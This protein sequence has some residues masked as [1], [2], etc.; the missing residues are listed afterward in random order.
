MKRDRRP[1]G[2]DI[3]QSIAKR[4]NVANH[5]LLIG[6]VLTLG[7][8]NQKPIDDRP[9]VLFISIDDLRP[10]LG[11]YDDPI[12]ITPNI[13]HLA[14]E[15]I[16]FRQAFCQAAVSAPSRASLMTGLRPDSTRVWHLGD[17]FRIIHPDAVTMPQYF[18]GSGYY[19]V[20]IGKIFHNYMPDSISWDEPDL[21]PVQYLREEWLKRDGETFYISEEVNRS[22]AIKRDSLLK[23]Q[24]VRYADGWN[25]GPAWEAADVHDTMYY[26]GAQTELAKR[27]L[28]RLSKMNQ[29]FFMGLG[30]FRPHLPFAVPKRYWD[31]YYPDEMP[32]A[33]NQQIPDGAPIY[34]M[35]SMY[36]LRGYDGFKHIGHP[37]SG[38]K[39][40]EDTARILRQGYYASVSYVDALIGDLIAHMKKLGIYDNTIIVIWGDH[41]W[42]LG[43]HNSW[44]K[45]TN[46]NVDLKVPVIIRAPD[47]NKRGVQTNAMIELVD[48]L[49][50][51]CELAGI[52]I[53]GYLQ[54]TS[55]VPL[56][57]NPDR[58][59]KTG[60]F[61]QFHRRPQESADGHR[62]MGYSLNT[63]K[64]HYIEWYAWDNIT[65]TKGEFKSTE[66]YDLEKDPYETVNIAGTWEMKEIING[67][68]AQLE[69]GWRRALPVHGEK[70]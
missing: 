59:W 47:Q 32:L 57:E 27:T 54:G 41:G 1:T 42:K 10:A 15:G 52:E 18:S 46:Y 69:A 12:A 66:L 63:N 43:D 3:I 49:P 11:V 19:T 9:N 58:E 8:D 53:P 6:A 21:R 29:P 44:G 31:M 23:L 60:V 50:S 45:M 38:Y 39:M 30:Y 65:G 22:Q 2:R 64:Y 51:L 35:N 55:V 28:T 5:S 7:C 17:E 61:S 33:T 48:L 20:N 40:P 34:S 37:A 36:E 16:T 62:Y 56:M 70:E 13:D 4:R 67:L 25:T 26:D 14:S 24:P 68:S